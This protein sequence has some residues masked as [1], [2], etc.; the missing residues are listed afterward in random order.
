MNAIP[1]CQNNGTCIYKYNASYECVCD[2]DHWGK[3]CQLSD[4]CLSSPCVNGRCENITN[5][6]YVCNC[7]GGHFGKLCER[8]NPCYDRPCRIENSTCHNISDSEFKCHCPEGET[9][10]NCSDGSWNGCSKY[11]CQNGG[12]CMVISEI[13][14]TECQCQPGF[15]GL[16]CEDIDSCS[17]YSCHHNGTCINDDSANQS[18]PFR[19]Q[20]PEGYYGNRCQSENPCDDHPC[21][22]NGTCLGGHGSNYMCMCDRIFY[23][24]HCENIHF[25]RLN[26]CPNGTICTVIENQPPHK[27]MLKFDDNEIKEVTVASRQAC[28][29]SNES[30]GKFM[31]TSVVTRLVCIPIPRKLF[32][33]CECLSLRCRSLEKQP[34][35]TPL[36]CLLCLAVSRCCVCSVAL[37]DSLLCPIK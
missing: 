22:N 20:C 31:D 28:I 27:V 14:D 24:T 29:C 1:V 5:S 4:P 35:C 34:F 9:I 2:T 3:E 37:M 36:W 6:E 7:D 33:I 16:L 12:H 25:C 18:L 32:F 21:W 19:C 17:P 26:T 15:K 23:G 13:G 11:G 30:S 10:N 8:Y